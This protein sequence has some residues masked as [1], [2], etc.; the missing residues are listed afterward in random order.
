MDGETI[1]EEGLKETNVGEGL[2]DVVSIGEP[3]EAEKPP[4]DLVFGILKNSRRREVLEYLRRREE[5][6]DI[7]DLAEH[8]AAIENETT[9]KELTSKQRKRVYVALYQCH[10]PKMDDAE[11]V[12]FDND[13]GTVELGDDAIE[14]EAYLKAADLVEFLRR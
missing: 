10:L 4:L 7:G 9:P 6:I 12:D 2:N 1:V 11:V 5:P 3:G 13:R 8:I 14:F